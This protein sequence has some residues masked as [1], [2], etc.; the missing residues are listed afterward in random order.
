MEKKIYGLIGMPLGHSFSRS[1]FNE[2]FERE[3]IDAEY[4]NFELPDVGDLMELLAELPDIAGLNVTLPYKQAVIPYMDYMSD[5]ASG[6]GAVNVIR[7]GHD[8]D[9]LRL[10]G[11][12]TDAI[13]FGE[14]L[15]PLLTAAHTRALV[16]GSGGASRAVIYALGQLG[17]D[18]VVVSRHPSEGQLSYTDLTPEVMADHKLIVNTTPVGMYPHVDECPDIPYKLLGP[19]YLCYDVVYNPTETLFMKKAAEH[20]ARTK[21]GLEMLH[22]QALA[23]WK[24][25]NE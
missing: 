16:L 18:A 19:D 22:L 25:W 12:N 6:V 1:F 8:G 17:I 11:Y 24:I 23:A 13:G 4:R 14:S 3:D 20:G 10:G 7:V 2:K 9:D 5:T 15:R 21:N